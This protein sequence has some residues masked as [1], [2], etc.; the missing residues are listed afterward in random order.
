M[1]LKGE[2]WKSFTWHEGEGKESF[3]VA[4]FSFAAP[5][6]HVLYEHSLSIIDLGKFRPGMFPGIYKVQK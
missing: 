4:Y 1:V 5:P 3:I 2:A 6:P